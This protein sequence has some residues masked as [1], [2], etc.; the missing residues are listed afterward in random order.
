[1]EKLQYPLL[2]YQL[3]ESLILGILVGTEIQLIESDLKKMKTVIGT[4]LQ[5]QYKK[6][7][8]YPYV[9]IQD[10]KLKI[11]EVNIRPTYKEQNGSFPLSKKLM[12]PIP[13]VY[14]AT[15]QGTYECYLP[16]FEESFYYYDPKQFE[17]LARHICTN[18]LNNK[19]PRELYRLVNYPKPKLDK[20]PLKVH[21]DREIDWDNWNA[22]RRFE[23]LER[24]AERHPLPKSARRGKG[25]FPEAAWEMDEKVSEIIE[26]IVNQRANL[27]V[28]GNHG[29]GKT[30]VLRQAIR[31][32]TNKSPKS[33]LD[34]TFWRIMPQRIT[35]SAKYLGEWEES[36][37][38][39]IEDLNSANGILW[40]VDLIRLLQT[41]G[42][43]PEVS[44]AA[45]LIPFMQQGKLQLIGEATL[46][47]LES[48]RRFLPG[49]VEN[50]QIV[51]ID[52]LS[53]KIIQKILDKYADFSS[54]NLGIEIPEAAR[55]LAYR[56]LLR[57]YPYESFPGKAV[58][59]LGQCVSIA[60]MND[61]K[62]VGKNEV[63]KNFIRQTGLPELFLRDDLLLDQKAL[64][65][66]F[67][68]QII[69]QPN[70]I[71]K[72]CGIVKI[73]KA[74]LN[75]PYKPITTLLF[76]G[77]TGVG[78]TAS[79]KALADYFFGIGKMRSPLI[80]ID[81]SEFQY[82]DQITR[83]IGSGGQAG[84]LVKNIRERPFAV[85]LL[86]EV[87]KANPTIFDALLTVLD[88]G[89]LVDAF[90]RVTNFR[91]T[92]IIMTT[93][94][95]ASNR[96][97]IGY[98]QTVDEETVYLSAIKNYFRPEFVN[99][100]DGI[101]MFNA[102]KEEDIRKIARKEL[103][104]LKHREGFIKKGLV[105]NF[106]DQVVNYLVQIGFHE[107]YGARPLQRA[108]EDHL[109]KPLSGW[110]LNNRNSKNMELNIDFKEKIIVKK[111]K[112]QLK[113]EGEKM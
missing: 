112:K 59:F 68:N 36:V 91:N 57:Y 113:N 24:L 5:R 33:E 111:G 15:T 52:E 84:Q 11:I 16:L 21:E 10:P 37:E 6:N 19:S 67:N 48:M 94:L 4:F 44:V 60:Q 107:K 109:I 56:L 78:K 106:S 12:V 41:G 42:R 103:E 81:M 65:D 82:P 34:Y 88:E 105:L 25:A 1:M 87:E 97:S 80:R 75:N 70:A 54:N 27:L 77:P 73:Y 72:L 110:L 23:N 85:L 26:K 108:L 58:K 38:W 22:G 100:I 64:S 31:K 74:G 14:G 98:S 35:A 9:E 30:A 104:D 92:I 50:F 69:G 51:Q 93:N 20:V 49:F 46:Q 13:L 61:Q 66:F 55:A 45:F 63:I 53:D 96:K 43:S 62:I 79:A 95:G 101:V 17:V 7:D 3:N 89:K 71:E 86:D 32:V 102:L 29:V 76:A 99:R 47:E 83:L 40:T 2:Y 18:I 8:E 28:V 90:G 39:L